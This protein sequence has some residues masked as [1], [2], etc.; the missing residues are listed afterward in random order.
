MRS[1]DAFHPSALNKAKTGRYVRALKQMLP[2]YR[3][4][5]Q[6]VVANNQPGFAGVTFQG[7]QNTSGICPLWW[8][9][10]SGN[11]NSD[12]FVSMMN[13]WMLDMTQP[14]DNTSLMTGI[15]V[16]NQIAL[17][18]GASGTGQDVNCVYNVKEIGLDVNLWVPPQVVTNM[19][20]IRNALLLQDT[21]RFRIVVL[22]VSGAAVALGATDYDNVDGAW[23][24]ER[25]A[26]TDLTGAG[27]Q[28][29][30]TNNL[31]AF[32][33]ILPYPRVFPE[34]SAD[35]MSA[36]ADTKL[37][38]LYDKWHSIKQNI[39]PMLHLS[40][41]QLIS[42]PV[43]SG[44][45]MADS[46]NYGILASATVPSQT[47][48][49]G[50]P[51]SFYAQQQLIR[52]NLYFMD[53]NNYSLEGYDTNPQTNGAGFQLDTEG[54]VDY[55][56]PGGQKT[57]HIDIKKPYTCLASPALMGSYTATNQPILHSDHTNILVFAIPENIGINGSDDGGVIV[58][59]SGVSQG[60]RTMS[61][62]VPQAAYQNQG[63]I[64]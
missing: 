18:F 62:E 63:V 42:P 14:P 1:N 2:T 3:I 59:T 21:F 32:A 24:W 47:Y 5:D 4:L 7:Y 13:I 43:N 11:P 57:V 50:T 52:N 26:E 46:Q 23:R 53:E 41:L 55:V 54:N 31:D 37:A 64:E 51:S 17:S 35:F 20:A 44:S 9:Q 61:I 28:I 40:N 56:I 25:V 16:P 34:D 19:D 58:W 27:V 10:T 8:S 38:V 30:L 33:S 36:M 12:S 15:P 6:L 22:E 48:P 45:I 60:R 49:G 29:P 39:Q